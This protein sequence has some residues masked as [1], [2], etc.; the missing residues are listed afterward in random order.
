MK[1]DR[2]D[3]I[4]LGAFPWLTFVQVHTDEGLTGVSDTFYTADAIR[5][6]THD[7]RVPRLLGAEPLQIEGIWFERTTAT[8]PL[9]RPSAQR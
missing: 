7:G 5:A 2:I 8:R 4:Q 6:F 9:G 1:I 3:T